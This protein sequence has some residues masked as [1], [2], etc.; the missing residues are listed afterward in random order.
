MNTII[1]QLFVVY[2]AV[3]AGYY[4]PVPSPSITNPNQIPHYYWRD[5][6]GV[7]PEDAIQGGTD[8][9]GNPTYVGQAYFEKFELLPVIIYVGCKSANATAYANEITTDKNIKILCGKYKENFEW[10]ATKN[11]E[12]HLLTNRILIVGGY[13][14][15]QTL[16][17]GRVQYSGSTS[18]SYRLEY[19]WRDYVGIIPEDAVEGGTDESGAPTYVGQTYIREYGLLPAIIFRGCRTVNT[20]AQDKEVTSDTNIK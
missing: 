3:I 12:T 13:E 7:I 11:E 1:A 16:H 14:V 9:Y 18:N 15:G 8:D 19:Y 4:C 5:Y 10:V 6:V 2:I 17:I 20:T